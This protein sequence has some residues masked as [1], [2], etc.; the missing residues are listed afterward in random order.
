MRA[1]PEA[2]LAL[3][4]TDD[5]PLA[6]TLELARLAEQ[7]GFAEIWTNESGHYRG[8]FTV[9]AAIASVTSS[10]GIGIGIV[11]PFHRHPSVIAMEAAT[12]DELSGGRV[13]LG[14]GAALWNLRNLGEADDRTRRP[15]TATIEAIRIVRA[16]L[17][18]EPGIES[19]IYTVSADAHLDFAPLRPDLPVYVGAVN[20]R[21]LRAGGAWA[22]AVELG[23]VTSSRYV[24]WAHEVIAEGA[25]SN[26]RQP[27]LIDVAA[28]LMVSIADDH[29]SARQA[30][31]EQL[32][33]YLFRVE[34]VMT[35]KSG[36][37]PQAVAA[38][39]REVR[40]NGVAAGA[41]LV[42]DEL[43][44]TFALAGDP[45]HVA[46][47]FA[48]YA[49]AGVK[50]LIAQNV[51]SPDRAAAVRLLAEAVLPQVAIAHVA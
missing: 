21:M 11:N 42:G 12:L 49:A 19:Q 33:Y 32:A 48:D 40:A 41:R 10:V 35:A 18:G 17:R 24:R 29:R 47:R 27:E 8:A 6:E 16:L 3:S 26:G 51:A 2:R 45:A 31:K 1:L 7:L 43:I 5:R 22:D 14:I 23:A 9:A 39:Q 38:V 36:A 28:P 46:R 4:L 37:D 13:R 50:G 44:D 25:R 34:G 30:V 15:L 20:E